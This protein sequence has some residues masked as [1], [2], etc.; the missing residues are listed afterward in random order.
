MAF[1]IGDD[2][3]F[4]PSSSVWLA[5]VFDSLE[6]LLGELGVGGLGDLGWNGGWR[7]LGPAA[8]R[9]SSEGTA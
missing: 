9:S 1:L 5:V 8:R 4:W 7:P 3:S 6:D 2:P